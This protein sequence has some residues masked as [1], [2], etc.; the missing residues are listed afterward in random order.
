LYNATWTLKRNGL[1]STLA[2]DLY[3]TPALIPACPW[4][5]GTLPPAPTISVTSDVLSITPGA[6]EIARWW[7]LRSHSSAGWSVR[8]LS[9]ADRILPVPAGTDRALVQAVDR[10]G[11]VSG[12]A[13]WRRP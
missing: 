6:G 8:I 2:A 5:D 9:G 10:A 4:L 1:A 3:K 13:E 12:I 7:T 11:N